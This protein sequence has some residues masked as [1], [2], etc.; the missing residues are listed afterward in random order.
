M[1]MTFL[2]YRFFS[3]RIKKI[4]LAFISWELH[5]FYFQQLCGNIRNQQIKPDCLSRALATSFKE[6]ESHLHSVA[7]YIG[8]A[9]SVG[10]VCCA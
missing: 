7:S 8:N 2:I 9:G 6:D 3:W 4:S 5:G 10:F 1:E